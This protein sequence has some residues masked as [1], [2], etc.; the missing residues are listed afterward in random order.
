MSNAF[1][2]KGSTRPEQTENNASY[3]A[4]DVR[5]HY[6]DNLRALAM[7]LGIVF[8]AALAYSPMMQ[9]LWM[10]ASSDNHIIV[11]MLAWFS[12]AF[13]MPLFFLVSGFFALMLID[14]R[15]I[16]GFI[17]Q[18]FKR[19]ALPFVIFLPLCLMA[20]ILSIG[21]AI[22]NIE[23]HS[24][25]LAFF[26]MMQNVPDAP[27]P[28][29]STMHLWFLFNLLLFIPFFA[30]LARTGFFDSK[31]SVF[32]TKPSIL[33]LVM[34]VFLVPA[35]MSQHLPLP[36]PERIYPQLWS[37][38]FFGIFFLVGGILFRLQTAIDSLLKYQWQLLLSSVILYG[39]FYQYLPSEPVT[40]EDMMAQIQP[41]ELSKTQII[42]AVLEA[43]I[44]WHMTL[45]CLIAGRKLLN[46]QNAVLAWFSRS[47]YWIYIVH[48]PVL[49]FLQFLLL[50]IHL[51]VWLE[52]VLSLF[53]TLLIGVVSYQA[54]VSNTPIGWL[55]NG[56]HKK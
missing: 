47:S 38:G 46:R 40:L 8:H 15:G 34:P 42:K 44:A 48:L 11:D 28:P 43:F 20:V 13:R 29:F 5:Y 24:P 9:N 10:A 12:H 31:I 22:E 54:L 17:G 55:L 36:A 21:W 30:L 27:P 39:L 37:F 53:G 35:L 25:M 3:E 52:F 23:N 16:K 45:F 51:N 41:P 7:L 26:K 6:M 1:N 49:F 2:G 32:V 19:I 4:G 56:R 14:K 50:D 33:L 18:R